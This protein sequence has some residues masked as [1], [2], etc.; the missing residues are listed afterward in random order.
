MDFLDPSLKAWKK[1]NE[2]ISVHGHVKQALFYS[3]KQNWGILNVPC[4]KKYKLHIGLW[5]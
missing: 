5:S 3:P 2:L 4:N 1:E